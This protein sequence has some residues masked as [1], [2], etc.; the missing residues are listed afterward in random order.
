MKPNSL[1]THV[2]RRRLGRLLAS[3]DARAMAPWHVRDELE[4]LLEDAESI[5]QES[6]PDDVV[7]MNSTVRLVSVNS[8]EEFVCTVVY[9]EDVDLVDNGISVLDPLGTNLIGCEVGNLVDCVR[10]ED[11]GPWRVAEIEY[12]PERAAAFHM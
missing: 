1:L 4:C 11:R 6:F 12:Q 9:P 7:T 8:A 10:Q 5:S 3:S 2:D